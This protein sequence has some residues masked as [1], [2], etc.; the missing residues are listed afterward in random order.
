L[1]PSCVM[2]GGLLDLQ[3]HAGNLHAWFTAQ[4]D[5]LFH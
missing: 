3:F 4:A 5:F 2:G 1:T